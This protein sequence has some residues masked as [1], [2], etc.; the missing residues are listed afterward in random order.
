MC[1]DGECTTEVDEFQEGAGEAHDETMAGQVEMIDALSSAAELAM[2]MAMPATAASVAPDGEASGE[3]VVV[4][5]EGAFADAA[6]A[7][8][9]GG[10]AH[11]VSPLFGIDGG[12]SIDDVDLAV[13][14]EGLA[15]AES[16]ASIPGGGVPLAAD[17]VTLDPRMLRN[18]SRDFVARLNRVAERMWNEH[19]MRLEVVEGF[20]TPGRQQELFAQGRSAP[21]PVVTWTQNSLHSAG[22]AA[23]V[24]VDG[25]PVGT[26]AAAILARVAREEGLS[27]LHP[28]DSGHVQLEGLQRSAGPEGPLLRD[29]PATPG[30]AAPA[31]G[32]APVAPTA[33]VARPARPGGLTDASPEGQQSTAARTPPS[34]PSIG[35]STA[36]AGDPS[37]EPTVS[38]VARPQRGEVGSAPVTE[39]GNPTAAAASGSPERSARLPDA[40]RIEGGVPG[41]AAPA[42]EPA[43]P[44]AYR[45][46]HVPIDGVGGASLQLGIRPGSVDARLN[47]SDPVLAQSLDR[48]LPEL[49][50]ALAARGMES[51]GLTVRVTPASTADGVSEV[52]TRLHSAGG[53]DATGGDASTFAQRER[54]QRF[55]ERPD[56]E[57]HPQKPRHDQTEERKP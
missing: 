30:V 1:T 50:Q 16:D 17:T 55:R 9:G 51:P 53:G 19:G 52:I 41:P 49:R 46:V 31:R 36:G 10:E 33:P 34:L 8:A 2:S 28:F 39:L 48:N 18:L 13:S 15:I 7:E 5:H 54:A 11:G 47:I 24:F 37:P 25:A 26:V 35:G 22:A 21:G 38:N 27:T 56:Q 20:R 4:A 40:G 42:P 44:A 6:S 14:A 12:P 23:D 43:A 3:S 45:R 57:D 32:V 29:R